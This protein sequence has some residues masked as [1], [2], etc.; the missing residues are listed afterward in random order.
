M[1]FSSAMPIQRTVPLRCGLG[2]TWH[3]TP[4]RPVMHV[5]GAPVPG[6]T[7]P[8]DCHGRPA[9]SLR[10]SHQTLCL[11]TLSIGPLSAEFPVPH[12]SPC[13]P[14][15]IDNRIFTP[16]QI[17]HCQAMVGQLDKLKGTVATSRPT[18]RCGWQAGTVTGELRW[19]AS[20]ATRATSCRLGHAA[21][22]PP[23]RSRKRLGHLARHISE[24]GRG[25]GQYSPGAS[26]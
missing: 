7:P 12:G 1:L 9:C 16:R 11:R 19:N 17:T 26:D 13:A 22:V 5:G 6:R 21:G 2:P 8:G 14:V 4:G 20:D 24:A 25:R 15:A 18:F 3:G 23:P 10:A